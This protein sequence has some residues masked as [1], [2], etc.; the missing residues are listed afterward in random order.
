MPTPIRR[1]IP[2]LLASTALAISAGTLTGCGTEEGGGGGHSGA[3][4][5]SEARASEVAAAWDGSQ[6]AEAWRKGFHPT[7]EHI[8]PP[9]NG[10]RGEADK[11]AFET[12]N[13]ELRS[14]LPAASSRMGQVTW[15]R[16]DSLT[17]PLTDAQDAYASLDRSSGPGPLTVTKAEPGVMTLATHRG[18]ATIP[19]WFF[20]LEGYDTP[21]KLAAVAP[22]RLPE[23]PIAPMR[24][25]SSHDLAPLRRLVDVA[26]DGRSVT[27]QANGGG[28]GDAPTVRVLETS[29]SV[30]LSA[31][32]TGVDDEP[33]TSQL[34]SEKLIV[35]LD[36][37]VGDRTLLDAFTG[38]PVPYGEP[39]GPSPSW[40]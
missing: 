3:A 17:L 30:V 23:P 2:L 16:G 15:E 6:A 27:V 32:L 18:P 13:F 5:A 34:D 7:G 20:I 37:P 36:R 25:T 39:G 35:R 26:A 1:T 21:L 31:S 28:C 19:A 10:L 40:R 24:Q 11:R 38:R 22:S 33:C 29:G 14:E 8:Q 9:E 4:L 12:R